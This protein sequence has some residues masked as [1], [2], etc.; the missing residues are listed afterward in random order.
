MRLLISACSVKK[1]HVARTHRPHNIL[2]QL[3]HPALLASAQ[4]LFTLSFASLNAVYELHA[5]PAPQWR[6]AAVMGAELCSA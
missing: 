3:I 4:M 5:F 2:R 1:K 6:D